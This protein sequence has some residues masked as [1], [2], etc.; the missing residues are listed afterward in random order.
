MV[1]K[2]KASG[3]GGII[4]AGGDQKSNRGI[5]RLAAEFPHFVYPALGLHPERNDISAIEVEDTERLIEENAPRIKAVGEIGL[6]Y[7]NRSGGEKRLQRGLPLLKRMITLAAQ[8]GLPVILHAPH[9]AA[10]MALELLQE[11]GIERAIFHWHKGDPKTTQAI[12]DSGYFISLTPEVCYCERDRALAKALPLE[13]M[14]LES[15]GPWPYEAEFKGRLTEP[16]FILRTLAS[17]AELKG[18]SPVVLGRHLLE[19]T[20]KMFNIALPAVK[21]NEEKGYRV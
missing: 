17:V 14:L 13:N 20:C 9:E 5:L 4:S 19:N 18:I 16:T 3:I 12:I 1:R 21:E 7:Y 15:D 2:W 6:P 8:L 11:T 10:P